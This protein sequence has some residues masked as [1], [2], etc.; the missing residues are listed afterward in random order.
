MQHVDTCRMITSNAMH[1]DMCYIRRAPTSDIKH[2][3]EYRTAIPITGVN[4]QAHRRPVQGPFAPRGGGA[5]LCLQARRGNR[6]LMAC[7]MFQA[8]RRDVLVRV[9]CRVCRDDDPRPAP[10]ERRRSLA[11]WFREGYDGLNAR[12]GC[13]G[14]GLS[15]FPRRRAVGPGGWRAALGPEGRAVQGPPGR[16]ARAGNKLK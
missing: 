9:R 16:L 3:H 4:P 14:L 12:P 10:T 7:L 6:R 13:N 11:A 8:V 1:D 2:G 15:V 5:P